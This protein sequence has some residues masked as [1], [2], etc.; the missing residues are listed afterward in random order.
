MFFDIVAGWIV[1]LNA[2][3]GLFGQS[4]GSLQPGSPTGATGHGGFMGT[5]AQ[6]IPGARGIVNGHP[7]ISFRL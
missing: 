1:H 3:Q 5:L 2:F 4:M 6:A 7:N